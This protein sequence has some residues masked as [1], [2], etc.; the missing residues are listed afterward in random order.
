MLVAV[1]LAVAGCSSAEQTDPSSFEGSWV[2]E[3]FGAVSGLTAADPDVVTE[4]TLTNGKATG[5]GGVNT[6]SSTYQAPEAGRVSFGPITATRMAG[7]ANAMDQEA[8]F[9][10]ALEKTTGFEINGD[11]LVQS[12][13]GNNTLAILAPSPAAT[14][15]PAIPTC[16]NSSRAST[17]EAPSST[18]L[19]RRQPQ[20]SLW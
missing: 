20:A 17:T 3:S 19:P 5:N 18:Q 9:L 16:W 13:L 1:S 12:D 14:S 7:P 2:L 15:S 4:M 6:F 10:S 11:S 8:A